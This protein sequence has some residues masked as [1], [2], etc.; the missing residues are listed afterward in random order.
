MSERNHN[1]KGGTITEHGYRLQYVGKDHHLADVR[2]YSYE[3]RLNAEKKLGR[4]LLP[5][6]Q[7][8][9]D[10]QNRLDNSDDNLIVT[11]SMAAHQF[12]HRS[13]NS[14]LKKPGEENSEQICAC[15]CGGIFNKFDR[16]G[17][18]RIYISGH[19]LQKRSA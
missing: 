16:F 7:V 5:E 15:G 13:P 17:R 14:K 12:L 6:E 10:N 8:H 9:H 11:S 2:G 1:Y 19:N 3:H 18:P 4:R